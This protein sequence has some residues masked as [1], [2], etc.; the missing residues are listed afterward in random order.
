MDSFKLFIN[1]LK[2]L[3]SKSL[4][5]TK[6]VL[7][8]RRHLLISVNDLQRRLKE[9]LSKINSLKSFISEVQKHKEAINNNKNFTFQYEVEEKK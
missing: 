4:T 7:E 1:K 8:R 3:P 5:L 6:N 9:E 2:H